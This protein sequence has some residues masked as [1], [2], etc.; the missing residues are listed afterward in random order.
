MKWTSGKFSKA[1][2]FNGKDTRAE[3]L[4]V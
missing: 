2:E 4:A 1:L 3:V